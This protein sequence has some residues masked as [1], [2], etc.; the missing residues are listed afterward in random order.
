MNLGTVISQLEQLQAQMEKTFGKGAK[1]GM[2]DMKLV[3][4][5]TD[6]VRAIQALSS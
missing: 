6:A 5:T 3:L 4:D 1:T 2:V